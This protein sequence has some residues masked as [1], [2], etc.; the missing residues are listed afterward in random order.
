MSGT[1]A[2]APM[3]VL[4]DTTYARRA[5]H[6]G[7]AVY[8][9]Q[10]QHSLGRLGG[11]EVIARA[12]RRRPQPAGGGLGSVRNLLD[13]QWWTG[14][15][16]PRLAS[17]LQADVIHH[18]L[19]ALAPR[20]RA[21]A[22]VITVHDLAFERLGRLF[23][24]RFRVYAHFAHRAAAR[25]AQAVICVSE[26][27]A[28]DVRSLWRVP[29]AGIIVAPHGPGQPL[30]RTVGRRPTHFLY[31]GDA[32]PRKNFD[33]LL[34]AYDRY[35]GRA[36]NPL[37]LVL[38]GAASA[39]GPGVRSEHELDAAGLAELYAGAAALVHPSL[40]EGFGLTLLEAMR[41]GVPVVAGR[42]PGVEEV[43]SDAARYADPRDPESFAEAMA[44]IADQ[45]AL[46]AAL[47]Q[48]GRSR[49][50]LFSWDASARAHLAAYSLALSD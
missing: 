16:L 40:Y 30:P 50:A 41:A 14:V 9:E 2:H 5:P 13:D 24:R 46:R 43:C 10:L 39:I 17:E 27:T 32:E 35:R 44:E 49:A 8:L 22:Q 7:T 34:A 47:W 28:N 23:D 36:A 33:L 31:V 11:I 25:R 6:S 12:N 38:A 45:P 29:P 21:P 42:V 3:R 37:E 48:R 15:E 18:P 19:P 26:A 20:S 1:Y 4:L